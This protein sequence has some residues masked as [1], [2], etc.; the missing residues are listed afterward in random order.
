LRIGISI[1]CKYIKLLIPYKHLKEGRRFIDII[2]VRKASSYWAR[3]VRYI[4]SFKTSIDLVIAY[5]GFISL[6]KMLRLVI[7]LIAKHRILKG[8][9][10]VYNIFIIVEIIIKDI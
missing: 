3:G 2:I 5:N 10:A 7:S 9:V 6:V 8:D 4:Y 1:T